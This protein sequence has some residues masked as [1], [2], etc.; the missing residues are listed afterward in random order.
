S[1]VQEIEKIEGEPGRERTG[2]QSIERA[3]AIL[4]HI[5]KHQEGISLAELSKCVGL[6]TSTTFHLVRTMVELGVVRQVKATKRYH[7]GRTLFGLAASSSSEIDLVATATPF[8]ESLARETGEP[9]HLGI[10]SGHNV[11]VAAR[12]AGTGA[13]Q[14]VERNGG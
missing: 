13:F 8:L 1:E 2:V 9:C 5:A 7:L 14:L 12:I 4:T 11:V 10:R 3:F 6:H